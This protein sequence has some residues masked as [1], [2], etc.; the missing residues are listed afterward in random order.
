MEHLELRIPAA[1]ASERQH[2]RVPAAAQVEQLV[3]GPHLVAE[4]RGARAQ[5]LEVGL[6]VLDDAVVLRVVVEI[7]SPDE[8]VLLRDGVD[9][10]RVA[11]VLER[12]A[13][14][15]AAQP[16]QR[17]ERADVHGR[18]TV[19]VEHRLDADDLAF[20][21]RDRAATTIRCVD[22]ERITGD[23]GRRRLRRS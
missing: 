4:P 23:A 12:A 6:V 10:V 5:E 16:M 1:A 2:G 21:D 8:P 20:E 14:A 19:R 15:P 3:P 11:H 7:G 13:L 22:A 17:V 9:D 18:L